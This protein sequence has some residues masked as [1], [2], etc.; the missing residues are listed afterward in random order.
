MDQRWKVVVELVEQRSGQFKVIGSEQ[1]RIGQLGIEVP[2]D[3]GPGSIAGEPGSHQVDHGFILSG[4]RC[5]FIQLNPVIGFHPLIGNG[6]EAFLK[7][8]IPPFSMP[9]MDPVKWFALKRFDGSKPFRYRQPFFFGTEPNGYIN[10]VF[11]FFNAVFPHSGI[12]TIK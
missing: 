5:Q 7:E 2:P 1:G 10:D 12:F 4:S 11:F 9:C 3:P 8:C 6:Y